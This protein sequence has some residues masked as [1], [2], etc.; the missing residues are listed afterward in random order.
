MKLSRIVVALSLLSLFNCDDRSNPTVGEDDGNENHEIS[1]YSADS[2][3]I[4][5][6]LYEHDKASTTLLLFHQGGSNA[7][8]EYKHIITRLTEKRYNVLA[9]DQRVGGQTYGGYNRTIALF[10]ENDYNYC[11]VYL[12]LEA[13]LKFII[14]L[15]FTGPK[16]IWGSSYS[17]SLAI[18][19]ANNYPDK[20]NAI[21]AFSP[22]SGG[23]M[24]SC[25]P[26]DYFLT[27]KMPLLLL[28]P[29][30]EMAIE[31]VAQQ[32]QLAIDSEHQTYIA[33]PGTHGSSMLVD[34]RID[35]NSA[36]HWKIVFD[37]IE[38]LNP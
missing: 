7:R 35:G 17:A 29:Q 21:L 24:Q 13:A 28:R 23:P 27:I 6:D 8:A 3:Q 25:K 12:D 4:Y 15:G 14:D 2:V 33:N 10:N 32:F 1:F 34:E 36:P 9:I 38:N 26:D 31:S 20:I 37:F 19:L 30:Q 5:G 18:K 11:D 16:I 22:A